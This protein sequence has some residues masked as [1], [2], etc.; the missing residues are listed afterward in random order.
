M[1]HEES[2]KSIGLEPAASE[3]NVTRN[4]LEWLTQ[5]RALPPVRT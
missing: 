5:V 3:P 2:A 1:T 4:Y